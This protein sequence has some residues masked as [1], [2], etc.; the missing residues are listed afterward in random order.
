MRAIAKQLRKQ[1]EIGSLAA[2]RAC[3]GKFE[4]W[5]EKLN[6][7]H[8]VKIDARPVVDRQ[9]FEEGNIGALGLNQRCLF[10]EVDCFDVRLARANRRAG[11][12]T[13]AAARAVLHIKLQGK[14]CFRIAACIDRRRLERRRRVDQNILIVVAGTNDA[15]RA[16]EAA[17][18]ALDAKVFFPDRDGVRNISLLE[19]GGADGKVP[20]AGM[21]L[22]GISSPRPTSIIDVTRLTKSGALATT[23][24]GLSFGFVA[25]AGTLTSNSRAS[26]ASTAAKFF[27]TTA[28][29]LPL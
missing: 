10:G 21:R 16:D 17:L 14:A 4:Q 13:K 23:I 6:A 12:H 9:A 15:V 19:R 11:F 5:L 22:T 27:A 29:P 8:L 1:L 26:V 18:P 7:A 24:G 2:A 25:V 20:S 28:S 3:A